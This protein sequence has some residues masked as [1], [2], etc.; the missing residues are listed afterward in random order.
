MRD[1][2]L[3]LWRDRILDNVPRRHA[4]LQQNEPIADLHAHWRADKPALLS[5]VGIPFQMAASN[6]HHLQFHP[7]RDR[8]LQFILFHVQLPQ[9]V[10]T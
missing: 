7:T 8:K 6:L 4:L 1:L 3:D 2:V 10:T 5:S 9:S